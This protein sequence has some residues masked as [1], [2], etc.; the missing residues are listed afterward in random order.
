MIVVAGTTGQGH[1]MSCD[2]RVRLIHEV[3]ERWSGDA[4]LVAG[5]GTDNVGNAIRVIKAAKEAGY[6]GVLALM[7][8]NH[9][10]RLESMGRVADAC[11]TSNS[12]TDLG[13]LFYHIPSLG[14]DY[15][16]D[17]SDLN[18][19]RRNRPWVLG[20]KDS[21]GSLDSL[22]SWNIRDSKNLTPPMVWIGSDFRVADGFYALRMQNPNCSFAVISGSGN[23]D[24]V[25]PNLR[26]DVVWA[27]QQNY[28]AMMQV[29]RGINLEVQALLQSGKGFPEALKDGRLIA[30]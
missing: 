14:R 27:S 22:L 17:P 1:L 6:C 24:R 25:L 2:Q 4:I 20:V 30:I 21:A 18:Q 28:G 26:Q 23:A 8:M 29:Q 19:V 13:L 12:D 3:G 5:T 11:Y 9:T 10:K 15:R 16:I 7:R